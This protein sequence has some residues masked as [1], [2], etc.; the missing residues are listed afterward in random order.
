L[1]DFGVELITKDKL[2][3]YN[4]QPVEKFKMAKNMIEDTY[5]DCFLLT[6]QNADLRELIRECASL[7]T[8]DKGEVLMHV[9]SVLDFTFMIRMGS[10]TLTDCESDFNQTFTDGDFISSW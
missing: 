6:S 7:R 2:S 1:S 5:N 4:A 9:G 8:V 10:L 3:A